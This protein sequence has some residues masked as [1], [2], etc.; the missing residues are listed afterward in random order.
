M[1]RLKKK[2]VC[3]LENLVLRRLT[4]SESF[5]WILSPRGAPRRDAAAGENLFI[6]VNKRGGGG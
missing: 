1:S 3:E 2:C 4:L 6:S 5:F